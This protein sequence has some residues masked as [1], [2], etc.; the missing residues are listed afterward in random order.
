MNDQL[1]VISYQS[2]GKPLPVKNG[3]LLTKYNFLGDVKLSMWLY[4]IMPS[5]TAYC[6]LITTICLLVTAN[7]FAQLPAKYLITFKDK[8]NSP[9]SVSK[10]LEFLSQRSVNRRQKQN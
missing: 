10:P 6:L 9:F 8:I 1:S 2:G 7:C 4:K 3:L 5:I